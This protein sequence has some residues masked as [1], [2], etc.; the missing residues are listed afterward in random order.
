MIDYICVVLFFMLV[1]FTC[2]CVEEKGLGVSICGDSGECYDTC[3]SKKISYQ[4]GGRPRYAPAN[5]LLESD[6]IKVK[7]TDMI[8][9]ELVRDASIT[10]YW[11]KGDPLHDRCPLNVHNVTRSDGVAIFAKKDSW[12]LEKRKECFIRSSYDELGIFIR[13]DGYGDA[14]L[15]FKRSYKDKVR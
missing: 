6:A 1:V 2:G 5:F 12:V 10:V 15:S 11:S 14:I 8:T 9:G 3:I 13:K 7:V 4:Y